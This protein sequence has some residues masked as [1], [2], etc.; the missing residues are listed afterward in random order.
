ME[1]GPHSLFRFFH[2]HRDRDRADYR[3][4]PA[5]LDGMVVL[6]SGITISTP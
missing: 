2:R 1:T 3:A 4:L 5:G 6:P